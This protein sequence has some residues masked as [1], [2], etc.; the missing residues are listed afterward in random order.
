MTP[1]DAAWLK[2]RP[3]PRPGDGG[4]EARGAV[5]VV[6]G[7]LELVGAV[8]L[9]G[10]AALRAGAGKLQI[11]AHRAAMAPLIVAMPEARVIALD[12]EGDAAGA[13]AQLADNVCRCDALVIGP[14]M[15][16]DDAGLAA[17]LLGLAGD[18]PLVL[19]AG[20]LDALSPRRGPGRPLVMTPHAG[21]MARL[22]DWEKSAVEADH[23]GAARQ[24]AQ[25]YGA[26]V[27]MKG[28]QTHLVAPDGAALLYAG[29]GPGLGTSGSGDV[30]SGLIGGLLARGA[31]PM[32]AAA[33]GVYLH[34]EAGVRLATRIG[35]LGFLAREIAPEAPGILAEFG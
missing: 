4:K 31:S 29:G 15:M 34:G 26:V 13:I 30:L 20:A 5:L 10:E 23:L 6:G 27:V 12:M 1:L 22:L 9:A 32:E 33:W 2:A 3:L 16:D 19:D 7:E 11:G 24:A 8:L 35:P 25:A 28:A 21:E 14:G 18:Q 17:G